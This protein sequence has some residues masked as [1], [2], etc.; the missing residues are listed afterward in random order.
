M[1]RRKV[2]SGF[3]IL[4][5]TPVALA[6]SSGDDDTGAAPGTCKGA[7]A[8]TTNDSGHTH[9][10]CVAQADLDNPPAAGST[11]TTTNNSGHTHHVT[12]TADQLAM[13]ASGQSVTVATSTDAGHL[14][15][16]TL[17]D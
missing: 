1:Q 10:V 16:V 17:A 9:F 13:I 14:H 7:G 12:L 4:A 15:H 5:V 6:C 2:F 8:N 11:Y 3:V